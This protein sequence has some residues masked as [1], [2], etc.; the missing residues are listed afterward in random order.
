[1]RKVLL[2]IVEKQL[3]SSVHICIFLLCTTEI[4]HKAPEKMF[5][6]SPVTGVKCC[7]KYE[8]MNN[9]DHRNGYILFLDISNTTD[10]IGWT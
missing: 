7:I 6:L 10:T 3:T 5:A 9:S 4:P 8:L 1:M 2:E